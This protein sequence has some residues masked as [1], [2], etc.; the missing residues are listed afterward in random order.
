MN[1]ITIRVFAS[2][3]EGPH[4]DGNRLRMAYKI[5]IYII[6]EGRGIHRNRVRGLIRI[7]QILRINRERHGLVVQIDLWVQRSLHSDLVAMN[8]RKTANTKNEIMAVFP[9]HFKSCLKMSGSNL[10]YWSIFLIL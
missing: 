9:S 7:N 6:F 1:S 10:A 2:L 5:R 8:K 3:I 4:I